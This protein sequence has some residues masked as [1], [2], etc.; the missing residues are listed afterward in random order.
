MGKHGGRRVGAGRKSNIGRI[1]SLLI[2]A[3]CEAEW[4]ALRESTS[5]EKHSSKLVDG[6]IDDCR[7]KLHGDAVPLEYREIVMERAAQQKPK[8]SDLPTNVGVA[9]ENLH[10]V[11][12]QLDG[13]RMIRFTAPQGQQKALIHLR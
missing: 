2:G 12:E 13:Q 4:G 1:D 6:Y 5:L 11:M 8:T 3:R 9:V 7:R 10:Y